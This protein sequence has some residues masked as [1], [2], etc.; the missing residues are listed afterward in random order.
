MK[1]KTR[2][3]RSTRRSSQT[4]LWRIL[5]PNRSWIDADLPIRQRLVLLPNP[6]CCQTHFAAKL[7]CSPPHLPSHLISLSNSPY[8]ATHLAAHKDRYRTQHFHSRLDNQYDQGSLALIGFVA[9]ESRYRPTQSWPEN[10]R[11]E[12]NSGFTAVPNPACC[13]MNR[14]RDI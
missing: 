6:F 1:N 14:K 3:V 2:A 4:R 13:R 5:P 8:L 11:L 9:A 7:D 12:E 10:L